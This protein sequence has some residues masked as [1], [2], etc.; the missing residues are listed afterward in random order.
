[1]AGAAARDPSHAFMHAPPLDLTSL[2][3]K[4]KYLHILVNPF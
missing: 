4:V 3:E 2:F 1:M